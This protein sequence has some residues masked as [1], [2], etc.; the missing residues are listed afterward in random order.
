M[1]VPGYQKFLRIELSSDRVTEV[2]S[3]VD[4]E[5]HTY[6]E[7]DNL[8]QNVIYKPV[9][10]KNSATDKVGAVMRPFVV[11]RR[12]VVEQDERN[13]TF[14]QFGFGS[15]TE[16]KTQSVL[17]PRTVTL[18]RNG[19]N[20]VTDPSFDPTKLTETDKLGISPANTKLT[21]ICVRKYCR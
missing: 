8:S 10:N 17:D 7:V 9:T 2:V 20:Y 4:Q 21:I 3:V 5:G 6:Y 15:E 1:N 14:I 12:F 19:K 11:P 13:S 18:N 16:L